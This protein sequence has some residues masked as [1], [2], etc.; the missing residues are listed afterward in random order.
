MR[1]ESATQ[2][3]EGDFKEVFSQIKFQIRNKVLWRIPFIFGTKSSK[4][5][6]PD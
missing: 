1:A 6:T 5:N 2:L 4:M 3:F